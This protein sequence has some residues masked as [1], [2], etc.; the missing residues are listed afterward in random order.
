MA[1]GHLKFIEGL[2]PCPS[3]SLPLTNW[4]NPPADDRYWSLHMRPAIVE[5]YGNGGHGNSLA[6]QISFRQPPFVR[7]RKHLADSTAIIHPF[8]VGVGSNPMADE[9]PVQSHDMLYTLS[10]DILYIAALLRA[11]GGC[12][13][14]HGRRWTY[15]SSG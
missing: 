3:K 14:W 12:A 10:R 8:P 4:S 6:S 1:L 9:N 2:L 5:M 13:G 11:V 7:L 15:M